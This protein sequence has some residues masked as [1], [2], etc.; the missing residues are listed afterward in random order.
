MQKFFVVALGSDAPDQPE[1]RPVTENQGLSNSRQLQSIAITPEIENK[2]PHRQEP[3]SAARYYGYCCVA[4]ETELA[5]A[6]V[7]I[8]A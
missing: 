3:A 4:A 1:G 5:E 8:S 2:P 6:G 7:A